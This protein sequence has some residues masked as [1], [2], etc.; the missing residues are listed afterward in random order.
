MRQGRTESAGLLTRRA[1]LVLAG[2]DTGGLATSAFFGTPFA[3]VT[4]I[5]RRRLRRVLRVLLQAGFELTDPGRNSAIR[6]A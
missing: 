2:I 6:A 5:T 1:G 4:A 3:T